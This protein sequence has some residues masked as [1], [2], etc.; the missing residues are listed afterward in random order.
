MIIDVVCTSSPRRSLAITS[1]R[2]ASSKTDA[3]TPAVLL[4]RSLGGIILIWTEVTFAKQRLPFAVATSIY[5]LAQRVNVFLYRV[6]SSMDTRQII[7]VTRTRVITSSSSSPIAWKY[8]LRPK[9]SCPASSSSENLACSVLIRGIY[10][11]PL[12]RT[13][14]S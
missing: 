2:A 12:W 13:I 9:S 11:Y 6:L 5:L 14:F 3:G 1:A 7:V 8:V 10:V 4:R